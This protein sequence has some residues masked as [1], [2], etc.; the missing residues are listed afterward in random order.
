MTAAIAPVMPK[1]RFMIRQITAVATALLLFG[2]GAAHAQDHAGWPERVFV[3]VD[4]SLQVMAKDFS[5]SVRI[6][7]AFVTSES[8]TFNAAY[9]RRSSALANAGLGVR[10]AG[11][12][13]VGV[14][15]SWSTRSGQAAF[16]LSVPSPLTANA[17]RTVSDSVDGLAR[18]E[19]AVH[20]EARYGIPLGSRSRV[21]VSA[22]PTIFNVK[23]DLV[24]SVEF[25]EFFGFEGID[26]TDVE[27]TSITRTAVGFNVGADTTVRLSSHFGL[28][29]MARYATATV[30]MNPGSNSSVV[31][32]IESRAGG[33][34]IGGG[35]RVLF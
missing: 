4:G 23:Q 13:G 34:Q 35:V 32:S 6:A 8:D 28:G 1:E 24:K 2:A 29:V 26:L 7:D 10:L 21:M 3:A 22:G 31:R 15:A 25:E 30:K 16:D 19:S 17:P 14:A 12:F 33:L 20:I 27:R 11:S 5:E 18:T 9:A